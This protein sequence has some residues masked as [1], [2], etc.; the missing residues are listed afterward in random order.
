MLSSRLTF[1]RRSN[2]K[3]ITHK[4][5]AEVSIGNNFSTSSSSP[6][7]HCI[8]YPTLTSFHTLSHIIRHSTLHSLHHTNCIFT[9]SIIIH[10]PIFAASQMNPPSWLFHT[11]VPSRYWYQHLSHRQHWLR[12]T[13]YIF[14]TNIYYHTSS[15][16][17]YIINEPTFLAV[18][19]ICSFSLPA[20]IT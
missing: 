10:H 15:N 18:S 3:T 13:N 11:F 19:Y 7:L 2:S 5:D 14:T 17:R 4:F 8:H 12:H 16:I 20:F 6:Y 1:L 9:T